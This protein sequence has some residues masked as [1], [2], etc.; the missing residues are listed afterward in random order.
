MKLLLLLA[1]SLAFAFAH[2]T[3]LRSAAP[4][5]ASVYFVTPTDG[6]T[7]RGSFTVG[8]G[9]RGMGVAPAGVDVA[10]TGHHHLLINQPDVD[11]ALPLPTSDQV[12]HFGKGQT[13]TSVGLPPGEYQLQLV[14]GNFLHIPHDPPIVSATITITVVE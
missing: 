3:D 4:E 11:Y 8:F 13:E 1:V 7:V 5:G 12:R 2:A 14:L 6:A 10:D 9:L